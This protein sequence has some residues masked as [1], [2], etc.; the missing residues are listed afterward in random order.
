MELTLPDQP[1]LLARV[2]STLS[3]PC[4]DVHS[5]ARCLVPTPELSHAFVRLANT[6]GRRGR[7]SC[8]TEAILELGP[9]ASKQL[10]L[11]LATKKHLSATA[12]NGLA[13]DAFWLASLRRAHAAH[14]LGSTLGIANDLSL[15]SVGFH[16]DIG[17][18]LRAQQDASAAQTLSDLAEAPALRRL[19]VERCFGSPHDE[20]SFAFC[21]RW[22]LAAEIA[23]PIRYHH[24][25]EQAPAA[26]SAAALI[27]HAGESIADLP[28]TSEIPPVWALADMRC[29]FRLSVCLCSSVP[30]RLVA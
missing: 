16:Q 26:H 24:Q 28:V 7:V 20:V 30:F 29:S 12:S 14:V 1:P 25:P 18:L 10:I 19:R 3:D 13:L 8:A 6:F 2:V 4:A 21:R 17:V 27:A 22:A 5:M 11:C 23:V 15:F 9:R